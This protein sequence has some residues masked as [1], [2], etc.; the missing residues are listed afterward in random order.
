MPEFVHRKKLYYNPVEYALNKIGGTWKMPILWRLKDK[1][2]RYSEL[3]RDIPK[4]THKM[5]AS[6][7]RHLENEGM[8]ERKVYPVIPPKVEYKLTKKGVK[9][10]PVIEVIKNFGI[11]MMKNDGVKLNK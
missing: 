2:C 11:E 7:L 6:Q 1:I 10:I 4:I 3:K 9:S 8:I 5:L